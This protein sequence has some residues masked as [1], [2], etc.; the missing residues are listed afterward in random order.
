VAVTIFSVK[1]FLKTCALPYFIRSACS[2]TIEPDQMIDIMA[3]DRTTLSKPD[4]AGCMQLFVG[5]LISQV[6]DG[7]HVKT[8]IGAFYL[9]AGGKLSTPDQR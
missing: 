2:D 9:S 5:E 7:K 3:Q 6:A 1:N 4:I 8:A